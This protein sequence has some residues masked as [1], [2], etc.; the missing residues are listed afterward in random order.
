[1]NTVAKLML[2][3]SRKRLAR[4]R[5]ARGQLCLGPEFQTAPPDDDEIRA[6]ED[7]C[8]FLEELITKNEQAHPIA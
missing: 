2:S 3:A 1:M 4:L 7:G 5:E 8:A 6:L